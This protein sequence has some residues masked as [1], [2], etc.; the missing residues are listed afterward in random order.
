MFPKTKNATMILENNNQEK[1]IKVKFYFDYEETLCRRIE[2]SADSLV[3][4][5]KK[6]EDEIDN[7]NIVLDSSDFVGGEIR[8]PVEEN[9]L[10]QVQCYGESVENVK[11]LDI[12]IDLW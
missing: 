1:G 9:F 5:I 2:I 7:E 10:P 8:M 3:D 4:A 11:G 6:L 12:V